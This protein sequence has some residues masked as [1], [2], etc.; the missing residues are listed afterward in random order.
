MYYNPKSLEPQGYSGFTQRENGHIWTIIVG[1]AHEMA[2]GS[3]PD[4]FYA[5]HPVCAGSNRFCNLFSS[6]P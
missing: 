2:S 4:F 3:G 6:T 5:V 1:I